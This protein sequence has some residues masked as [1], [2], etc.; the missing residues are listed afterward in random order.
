MKK[1]Q[2]R[3]SFYIGALLLALLASPAIAQQSVVQP[4]GNG[5]VNWTTQVISATVVGA[6]AAYRIPMVRWTLASQIVFAWL[7]TIP[8]TGLLGAIIFLILNRI[9]Y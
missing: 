8:S 4:I 2:W 1:E 7:I 6:G 3:M 5:E 9:L